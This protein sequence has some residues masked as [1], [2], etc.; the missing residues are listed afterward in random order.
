MDLK[1]A[2]FLFKYSKS[3]V[4]HLERHNDYWLLCIN[5]HQIIQT[6]RGQDKQYKTL[7][8]AIKDIEE[9]TGEKIN[10]LI[11]AKIERQGQLC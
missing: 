3:N 7:E 9:M 4:W 1:T 5:A 6:S 10:T 8:A 2:G 11:T